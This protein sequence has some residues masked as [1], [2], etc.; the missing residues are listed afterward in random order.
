MTERAI[1]LQPAVPSAIC[2]TWEGLAAAVE[3]RAKAAIAD[4]NSALFGSLA[5]GALIVMFAQRPEVQAEAENAGAGKRGPKFT[6]FGFVAVQLAKR[7]GERLPSVRHLQRCARAAVVAKERNII[8][9]SLHQLLDWKS[10]RLPELVTSADVPKLAGGEDAGAKA[11]RLDGAD[12]STLFLRRLRNLE[13]VVQGLVCRK[14][15]GFRWNDE[16]LAADASSS[17]RVVIAG[18]YY[19]SWDFVTTLSRRAGT[20][21]VSKTDRAV[22]A[23]QALSDNGKRPVS[24]VVDDAHLMTA[25]DME[26]LA[27]CIGQAAHEL[28]IGVRLLYVFKR[29]SHWCRRKEVAKDGSVYIGNV[30]E[31]RVDWPVIPAAFAARLQAGRLAV[32]ELKKEGLDVLS[33][34]E[35]R[36]KVRGLSLAS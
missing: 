30:W 19:G 28:S 2:E 23:L 9:G 10:A 22:R 33:K 36:E 13:T 24:L 1:V 18:A 29:Y 6:P 27:L 4:H 5:V 26:R 11:A 17:P 31:S 8:K 15:D 14:P 20:S 32:S 16:G 21:G 12:F 35:A 34:T 25:T 7:F 3:E